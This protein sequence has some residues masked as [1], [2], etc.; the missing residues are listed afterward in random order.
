MAGNLLGRVERLERSRAEAARKVFF[1][2]MDA[3]VA[4]DP[5]RKEQAL[6][7]AG[8]HLAKDDDLITIMTWARRDGAVA[9]LTAVYDVAP[10]GEWIPS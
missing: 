2:W 8:V 5:V 6:R 9:G 4:D 10:S 1:V 7:D 3:D